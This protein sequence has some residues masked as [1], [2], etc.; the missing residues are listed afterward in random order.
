MIDLLTKVQSIEAL[1]PI[2]KSL[3]SF[4]SA[5][6]LIANR[7]LRIPPSVTL[8]SFSPCGI[9]ENPRRFQAS[10][11]TIHSDNLLQKP[12]GNPYQS[13]Q[14]PTNPYNYIKPDEQVH[15]LVRK[16]RQSQFRED[17]LL[18]LGEYRAKVHATDP[19]QFE[20]LPK[21]FYRLSYGFLRNFVGFT[22][23]LKNIQHFIYR[24]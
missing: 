12:F 17:G 19:W 1:N 23:G 2:K 21:I 6:D 8:S 11:I 7:N 22:I 5:G 15:K 20:G 14:K 13:R 10:L 24:L 18:V 16:I 3:K 9:P 4:Q